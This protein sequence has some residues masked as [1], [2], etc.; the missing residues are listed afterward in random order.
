MVLFETGW[1][2]WTLY[3]ALLIGGLA[4]VFPQILGILSKTKP[5]NKSIVRGMQITKGIILLVYL[6]VLI[7]I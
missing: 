1:S 4:H 7:F 3:L 2:L 5:L 6:I